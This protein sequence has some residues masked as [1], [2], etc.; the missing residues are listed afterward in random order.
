MV[1]ACIFG[2][3]IWQLSKGSE[4]DQKEENNEWRGTS[5][6]KRK[7]RTKKKIKEAYSITFCKCVVTLILNCKFCACVIWVTGV[8][9][10]QAIQMVCLYN[11]K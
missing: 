11:C 8:P 9:Q 4:K 5:D 6:R 10:L 1:L 7:P 3:T 2:T